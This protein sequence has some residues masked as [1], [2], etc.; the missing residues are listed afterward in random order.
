MCFPVL[1]F[2][3]SSLSTSS[4]C[5]FVNICILSSARPFLD[6]L[7]F[8]NINGW[9]LCQR[10][11][12][13]FQRQ[14]TYFPKNK[15]PF[16]IFPVSLNKSSN[17]TGTISVPHLLYFYQQAQNLSDF[18]PYFWCVKNSV[19]NALFGIASGEIWKSEYLKLPFNSFSVVGSW[20]IFI[21][22][23]YIQELRFLRDFF[24]FLQ[25]MCN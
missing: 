4:L 15:F 21:H 18:P 2:T 3:F 14:M 10:I 8:I 1:C 9:F 20:K 13:P 11:F 19:N 5:V 7:L 6:W 17:S 23:R 24:F 22:T 25:G 16:I 12:S